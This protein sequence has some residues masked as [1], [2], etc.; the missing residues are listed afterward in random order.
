MLIHELTKNKKIN[1]GIG[2][3]FGLNNPEVSKA[4]GQLGAEMVHN[5]ATRYTKDPR[6]TKITDLAQRKRAIEQDEY[7]Q[8]MTQQ[9]VEA[10]N[11]QINE[12]EIRN[13]APLTNQQY[14]QAL[15]NWLDKVWFKGK[16]N[17]VDPAVQNRVKY[18][19]GEITKN[20]NNGE[21]IKQY[22]GS[23]AAD[24]AAREVEVWT[25][26]QQQQ[27]PQAPQP[28]Q[29]APVAVGGAPKAGTPNAAELAKF[30]QLV[31]SAA[32]AQS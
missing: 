11:K 27:A 5:L 4:W 20:R 15:I 31:A 3:F 26:M 9:Y 7:L 12:L 19:A 14:Q 13:G 17:S 8:R 28:Q 10:W 1:E 16:L 21:M 30:D 25:T 22:F 2:S 23:L 29:T 18:H 24:Q 32:K 6:Y